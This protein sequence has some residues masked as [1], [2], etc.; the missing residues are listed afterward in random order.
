VTGAASALAVVLSYLVGSIP[1]GLLL[2]RAAGVDVRGRGSG[3]IGAA[4]VARNAGARLGLATLI[5]DTTKGAIPVLALRALGGGVTPVAAAGVAAVLGH[6]FPVALRFAGGK[7]VATALGAMLVLAP[8]VALV[9]TTVFLVAF[10]LT[11]R[12]SVGS[13][14][15]ALAAPAAALFLGEPRAIVAACAAMAAVIVVRHLDNLGRLRRG[16]EPRFALPKR[17]APPD[18]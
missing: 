2:G 4:N 13:A 14:L 7:G 3:N 11:R 17:Q 1:F 15:G 12:V 5:A 6:C 18:N 8:T 10:A 9:A 16:T